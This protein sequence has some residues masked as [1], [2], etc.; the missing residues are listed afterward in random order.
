[1]LSLR[2]GSSYLVSSRK[3]CFPFAADLRPAGEQ[4]LPPRA[5]A[6]CRYAQEYLADFVDWSGAAFFSREKL[7]INDQPAPY[8]TKCDGV[9]AVIDT[10]VKTGTDH[11]ATAVTF[12]AINKY[13]GIPL[14]ILD[15]DIVQIFLLFPARVS[16]I[17]GAALTCFIL[18]GSA[19][20]LNAKYDLARDAVRG[21]PNVRSIL[22][23]Q[24]PISWMIGGIIALFAILALLYPFTLKE[25][26]RIISI[27]RP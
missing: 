21:F 26:K 6:T 3:S 12:F 10:A 23:E 27:P 2:L 7:L 13:H 11:D 20:V 19:I 22:A 17:G 24:E 18:V 8:P 1:V 4:L 5:E 16:K 15:W 9:F 25:W 14:L